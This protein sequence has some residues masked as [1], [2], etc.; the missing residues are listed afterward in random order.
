MLFWPTLQSLRGSSHAV[1]MVTGDALLTA[2]YV[3]GE[4]GITRS[5]M[6]K[7]LTLV[8][9]GGSVRAWVG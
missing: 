2:I 1:T 9:K 4:V 5:D 6:S 7:V 8:E 3:A